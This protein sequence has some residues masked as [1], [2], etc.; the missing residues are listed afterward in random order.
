MRSVEEERTVF[1]LTMTEKV[2]KPILKLKSTENTGLNS[3]FN[4]ELLK[5]NH[6]F[7][8]CKEKNQFLI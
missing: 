2:V 5:Y 1:Q 7:F 6:L 3:E 8:L 4:G